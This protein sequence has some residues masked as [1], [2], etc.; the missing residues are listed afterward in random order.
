MSWN[1]AMSFL[2]LAHSMMAANFYV[3]PTGIGDGSSKNPGSLK[4]AVGH[5]GWAASILPGDTIYLRSGTYGDSTN[6]LFFR[7]DGA[8]NNLVTWKSYPGELAKVDQRLRFGANKFHRFWGIEFIN[9]QKGNTNLLGA[10]KQMADDATAMS[11]NEWINCIVHDVDS[12]WTGASAGAAVRG[13]ILWYVGS[14]VRDHVVYPYVLDFSGNISAWVA[15]QTIEHGVDGSLIR[16]NI[17]FGA[18][19][20]V[21]EPHDEVL[22]GYSGSVLGN[23]L[24]SVS[25]DPLHGITINGGREGQSVIVSG[26]FAACTVPMVVSPTLTNSFMALGNT[27]YMNDASVRYQVVSLGPVDAGTWVVNSNH[28]YSTKAM[29]LDLIPDGENKTFAQWKTATGF[30][31]DSTSADSTAPPDSVHVFPNADEPK[32]AHIAIYNFSSNDLVSVRLAG[33]LT[34]GDQYRL[35]S[36]QNFN[37]GA[38][39]TGIYNGTNIS[40]PM[41]NLTTAPLLYGTNLGLIRPPATSPAFAAFVLIGAPAAPTNFRVISTP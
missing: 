8:S 23:C 1:V 9:S 30:D 13:C 15:G 5:T 10:S 31:A 11:Y 16:S 35:Y 21:N 27:F 25:T 3:S 22:F 37:F 4:T 26:N 41:T 20:T 32:R 28:Y 29:R 6:Y 36:A 40:V 17:M 7:F 19:Q 39:Q 2:L 33:V 18:G 34:A 24:Y 38:I 12:A 14:N